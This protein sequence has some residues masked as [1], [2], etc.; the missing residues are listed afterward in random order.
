MEESNNSNLQKKKGLFVS[1]DAKKQ[2]KTK[3]NNRGR[4]I[5]SYC[6]SDI[7]TF[8]MFHQQHPW[9]FSQRLFVVVVAVVGAAAVLAADFHLP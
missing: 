4:R 1:L 2:T 7:S 5:C 3:Q 8:I 9:N 6:T